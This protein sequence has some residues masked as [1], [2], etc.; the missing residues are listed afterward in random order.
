MN[1]KFRVALIH[2]HYYNIVDYLVYPGKG[3]ASLKYSVE[4]EHFIK[5]YLNLS[6]FIYGISLQYF[7]ANYKGQ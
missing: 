2:I 7:Y 1:E 4:E 6:W 3:G 5:I